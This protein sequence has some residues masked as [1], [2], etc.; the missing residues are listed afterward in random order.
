MAARINNSPQGGPRFEFQ[1]CL[2]ENLFQKQHT[3]HCQ[4][5]PK[6]FS[7][8]PLSSTSY[9]SPLETNGERWKLDK[10]AW[11]FDNSADGMWDP[12]SWNVERNALLPSIRE[13]HQ[14][15][16][17]FTGSYLH[18]SMLLKSLGISWWW[19]VGWRSFG[20]G[21]RLREEW[22]SNYNV[23]SCLHLSVKSYW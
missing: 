12:P 16:P 19:W 13:T 15:F 8:Y 11:G 21:G 4:P 10:S 3:W 20:R 9:Q 5:V 23:P 7:L 6:S 18:S 1:D 22:S 2:F 14:Q 17:R